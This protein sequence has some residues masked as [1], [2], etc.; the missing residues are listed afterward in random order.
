MLSSK[1]IGERTLKCCVLDF[2]V[3]PVGRPPDPGKRAR[4]WTGTN[5]FANERLRE[6]LVSG[7]YRNFERRQ[8]A[9]IKSHQ[10]RRHK[11]TLT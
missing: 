9:F 4:G 7:A 2:Y 10:K 6:T 3:I 8:S 5:R 1:E 11:E